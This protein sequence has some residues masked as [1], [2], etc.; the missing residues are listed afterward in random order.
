MVVV[1]EEVKEE[2]GDHPTI[3][4]SRIKLKNCHDDNISIGS[5]GTLLLIF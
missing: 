5:N 2:E 1:E 3:S 4:N